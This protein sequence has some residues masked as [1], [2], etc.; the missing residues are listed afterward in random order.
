LPTNPREA[1]VRALGDAVQAATAT[2]DLGAA[3]IALEALGKLLADAGPTIVVDPTAER[4]TRE[5]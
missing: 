2:G 1:F 5:R 4:Q 3:R